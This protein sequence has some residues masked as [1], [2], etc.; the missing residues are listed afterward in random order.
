MSRI[1]PVA[2]AG[3]AIVAV[4]PA[5]AQ[6]ATRPAVTTGLAGSITPQSATLTG[7]V[8]PGGGATTYVFEY[9]KTK[10]YG[11]K[12]PA[13][14]A[15]S[16]TTRVAA[17]AGVTGLQSASTYHFRI[18]ARNPSGVTRGADRTFK[19]P[20][21][22]LGF[23]VAANPNPVAFGQ[24]TVI[25]GTLGGTGSANRQV[26]LQQNP[27]PYA[28]GFQPV[29]NVQLTN[30]TGGF[31]FP[32]L[33]VPVNT[34]YRVATTDKNPVISPVVG[35][36]VL[37]DVDT[38][39]RKTRVYRGSRLRFSGKTHPARDGVQVGVQRK[40]GR[41][42]KTIKGSRTTLGGRTFSRYALRATIRKGG[43][44]R[45]FVKVSDGS[46][47]SHFGPEIKIRTRRR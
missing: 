16:G 10:S 15:G 32:L 46:Y 45:V 23:A 12:T 26:Q 9:G 25:A 21:Q 35:A 42:W 44:Y 29:G 20:R 1:A 14:P 19:T 24:P 22:P 28:T 11:R 6:A 33:S 7:S 8:D 31:S 38:S 47:Q 4:V 41:A 40:D 36:S 43:R 2:L 17:T 18:V 5:A 37:I 13:T 30:S 3:V 27:W 39:V 34:Q